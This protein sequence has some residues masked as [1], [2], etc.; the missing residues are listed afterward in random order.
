MREAKKFQLPVEFLPNYYC[1][2]IFKVHSSQPTKNSS[3]FFLHELAT[4]ITT[5]TT[6]QAV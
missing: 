2:V 5:A 4:T 1:Y 6:A 3:R